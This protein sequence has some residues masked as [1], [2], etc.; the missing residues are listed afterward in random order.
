MSRA[1]RRPVRTLLLDTGSTM[2]HISHIFPM[3]TCSKKA[4]D[5]LGRPQ[6]SDA[7]IAWIAVLA[8]GQRPTIYAYTSLKQT[9]HG[10]PDEF[11]IRPFRLPTYRTLGNASFQIPPY[12]SSHVRCHLGHVMR[13]VKTVPL[14]VFTCTLYMCKYIC[15]LSI[16]C[17]ATVSAL[18]RYP[19]QRGW[20][21]FI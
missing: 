2:K 5:A 12:R 8:N 16:A 19:R 21:P 6:I 3:W 18:H 11:D 9:R 1:N 4:T 20:M 13:H 10:Q 17:V 14:H 7:Q 15:F